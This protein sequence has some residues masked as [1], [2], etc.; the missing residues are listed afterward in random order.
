MKYSFSDVN[1]QVDNLYS[2]Y[3]AAK[4]TEKSA[5]QEALDRGMAEQ[6]AILEKDDIVDFSDDD[7]GGDDS[8][9]AILVSNGH[10]V[11]TNNSPYHQSAEEAPLKNHPKAKARPRPPI[12][13]FRPL[14]KDVE[15]I[16]IDD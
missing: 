10:N 16:V 2:V 14:P 13:D 9:Q 8:N 15:I 11:A 3:L 6:A 1:P 4:A 7:D 12:P 5:E